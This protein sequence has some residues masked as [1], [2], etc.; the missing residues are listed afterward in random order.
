MNNNQQVEHLRGPRDPLHE[1]I[2]Q[3]LINQLV[4]SFYDKIQI[5]EELGP[6]FNNV[7][8]DNWPEHL[9]RM[10]AFWGSIALKT[11][12]YKGRPVPKHVA[13]SDLTPAHFKIWLSLFRQTAIEV[14]GQDIG[15]HFIDRAE[16]IAE[17]LQLAIFFQ[18]TIVPKDAFQ[19]GELTQPL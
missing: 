6:I 17:S 2:T 5:H 4:H 1:D 15:L 16:K 19:N 18:G 10:C 7:I 11:G 14:C 9:E 13:L 3:D 12:A 8:K